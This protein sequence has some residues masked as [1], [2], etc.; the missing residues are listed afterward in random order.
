MDDNRFDDV[1]RDLPRTFKTPPEPP[2]DEMWTVIE[3][4]HFNAPVSKS[5]NRGVM[6]DVPFYSKGGM[7]SPTPWLAAAA[8]FVLGIGIGRYLPSGAKP[9]ANAASPSAIAANPASPA[10]D[11]SAV[12]DAYRD[13][14]NRYLG[15]AAALLI[16]LPAKDANGKTDAT[17]AAKATDLLV[18]TRLLIDSPAAAQD[19]K[20]HSLLEDLELVLV[21]IARLRSEKN[22]GDL[23]LIHQAVEQGDVLSRLNSAVAT[24]Q[25]SE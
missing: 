15:Q 2:F 10:S 21:Q 23:D 11:T 5:P 12:A 17:F 18:T 7:M 13:Q 25:S 6:P 8:A 14:T 16:S 1:I 24:T 3:D 19:P 20:L 9:A 22:M 4:A